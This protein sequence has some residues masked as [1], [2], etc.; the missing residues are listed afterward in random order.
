MLMRAKD[1]LIHCIQRDLR[2]LIAEKEREANKL[3]ILKNSMNNISSNVD[4]E[5]LKAPLLGTEASKNNSSDNGM[6]PRTL[7]SQNTLMLI[8]SKLSIL[9]ST[10]LIIN[11]QLESLKLSS[12]YATKVKDRMK[13]A[14]YESNL[15]NMKADYIQ[16]NAKENDSRVFTRG[17]KPLQLKAS[18]LTL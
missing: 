16:T 5:E 3:N 7:E 17:G 10:S 9:E 8:K 18:N 6:V 12:S 1:S 14:Q 13:S 2:P 15:L 11:E 4:E